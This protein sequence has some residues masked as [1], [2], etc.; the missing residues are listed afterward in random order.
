MSRFCWAE[1]R[2]PTGEALTWPS[3]SKPAPVPEPL[4][5]RAGPHGPQGGLLYRCPQDPGDQARVKRGTPPRLSPTAGSVLTAGR[6]GQLWGR[7]AVHGGPTRESS[8]LILHLYLKLKIKH[9]GV[10]G[11]DI[12]PN[13]CHALPLAPSPV[14]HLPHPRAPFPLCFSARLGEIHTK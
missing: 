13:D 4:G 1:P 10:S 12:I 6:I 2:G 9:D 5:Q 8:G 3:T 14:P 11:S 7:L